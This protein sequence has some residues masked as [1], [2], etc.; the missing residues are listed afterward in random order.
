MYE[1][2]HLRYQVSICSQK[3]RTPNPINYIPTKVL[4]MICGK[5][6]L[7]P[8]LVEVQSLGTNFRLEDHG[9]ANYPFSLEFASLTEYMH[10][11]LIYLPVELEKFSS[12]MADIIPSKQT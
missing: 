4:K 10:Y 5:H 9:E 2:M 11:L 8:D 6:I 12:L 3:T 1:T 7:N